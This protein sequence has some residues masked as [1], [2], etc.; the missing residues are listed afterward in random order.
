MKPYVLDLRADLVDRQVPALVP[1]V[2][3]IT[4]VTLEVASGQ[5]D[6]DSW[7]S[8]PESFSL[9]RIKNFVNLE[10]MWLRHPSIPKL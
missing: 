2:L 4:K 10:S 8:L 6:K 3:C 5:S 7:L 1:C 9:E